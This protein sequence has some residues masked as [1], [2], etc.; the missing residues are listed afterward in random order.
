MVLVG[1][2]KMEDDGVDE[3]TACPRQT[4]VQHRD[5]TMRQRMEE[6]SIEVGV[7]ELASEKSRRGGLQS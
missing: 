6:T 7:L 4:G 1:S 3:G 2:M 5:A